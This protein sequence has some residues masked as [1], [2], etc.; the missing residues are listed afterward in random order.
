MNAVVHAQLT[1]QMLILLKNTNEEN[2][3]GSYIVF[4]SII[5][6]IAFNVDHFTFALNANVSP[7]YIC[8]FIIC[9]CDAW[10]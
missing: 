7:V 9:L 5:C 1:F 10:V 4:F 3:L 6:N 2:Q 8:V